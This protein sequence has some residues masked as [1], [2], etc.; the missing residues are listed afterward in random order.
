MWRAGFYLFLIILTIQGHCQVPDDYYKPAFE[1]N[2][3]QLKIA[4]YNIIKGHVEYPYSSNSTDTWDILKE[5]DRDPDNPLNV[6]LFYTGWSVNAAQEYNNEKGWNREHVWAKSRGN[7][8]T[9]PGPGT[10]CHHLRP[11]DITVNAARDNRWFDDCD[12]PYKDNGEYTG[13][14]TSN[15]T[16]VWQPR[17]A[18]K[19]DVARIIFYM[20]VRYEGDNGEPDLEMI[21]YLPSNNYTK[22]PVHARQSTLL[23][24]HSEDP[25]DS[26][27]MNRN[28]VV[29]QY[30]KNRNPF[31]D[32]PEFANMIW[33]DLSNTDQYSY[34][35][36]LVYPNPV[37]D[38]LYL[39]SD[40]P[41]EICLLSPDGRLL[42]KV[43]STEID[44]SNLQSGIYIV[45]LTNS[46]GESKITKII[47]QKKQ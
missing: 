41:Q 3:S 45:I 38:I 46:K 18:V 9:N 19:G 26:F 31:I 42:K 37:N 29:F 44:I 36:L 12:V 34:N 30:Q 39:Y 15:D 7:F 16:H 6:I 28:E 8:G 14:Y 20:A 47:K 2:G 22:D 40:L 43:N 4:L 17:D 33:G 24:W 27:E 35:K 10:D 1:L 21:D 32:H 13:C 25:V 23:R 5:S 11:S